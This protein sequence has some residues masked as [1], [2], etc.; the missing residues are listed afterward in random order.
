MKLIKGLGLLSFLVIISGSCFDPPEFPVVPQIEFERIEFVNSVS[1]SDFDSLN[2]YIRF[3]DGDGDLG[4]REGTEDIS[5]PYHNAFFYQALD[6]EPG[7]I[8]KLEPISTVSGFVGS[9][10]YDLLLPDP[11]LGK[12][13]VYSSRKK[14]GF[15]ALP[16]TFH[17]ADYEYLG[18][19]VD[20][21]NQ[22]DGRRL[23]IRKVDRAVLDPMI[24]LVDSIPF[25]D[26]PNVT[27]YYQIRDTLYFTPNQDH[28]NIEVDF[29][30]KDPT[31]DGGFREYDWRREFCTT[32]DGRF[33]VFSDKQSSIDGTLRYSM[34]SFGFTSI[35]SIK[36]L[37]L[38]VSIKDRERHPSY[39]I[40]T[41]EFTLLD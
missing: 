23:L 32:F 41:N 33:P 17:C 37:K 29:L 5:Y 40:E 36:T 28:Y 16:Q 14:D 19:K 30:V 15:S 8:A 20:P 11:N 3:K 39:P 6:V 9:E 27:E 38:R 7:E 25:A 22:G 35:F 34:T 1:P 24:K 2:L 31:A 26:K 4:F 10:E 12:L 13:V 21:N 18:G